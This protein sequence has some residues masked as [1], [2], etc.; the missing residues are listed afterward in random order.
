MSSL[1]FELTTVLSLV[2]LQLVVLHRPGEHVVELDVH[3]MTG[4][5]QPVVGGQVLGVVGEVGIAGAPDH[6]R[7]RVETH[8]EDCGVRS[9]SS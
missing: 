2:M 8:P 3:V 7:H 6:P 1:V 5:L 9:T 4:E